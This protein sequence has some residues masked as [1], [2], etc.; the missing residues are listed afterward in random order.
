MQIEYLCHLPIDSGKLCVIAVGCS[1]VSTFGSILVTLK[2]HRSLTVVV[3]S[4][5]KEVMGQETVVGCA[6]LVEEGDVGL[7]VGDGEG[8]AR[9]IAYDDAVETSPHTHAVGLGGAADDSRQC[10][11]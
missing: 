8:L 11:T 10:G 3:I 6:V 7:H 2:G 5:A 4:T 1:G 9:A